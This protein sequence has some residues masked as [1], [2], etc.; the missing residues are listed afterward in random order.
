[1]V[2]VQRLPT[3]FRTITPPRSCRLGCHH[4]SP[5]SGGKKPRK[6]H[7]CRQ[8]GWTPGTGPIRQDH[9]KGQKTLLRAPPKSR[10]CLGRHARHRRGY[11]GVTTSE[12]DNLAAEVAA[13]NAVNHPDYAQ[14]A[15]RIAVSN[16]HK[17]TT[18]VVRRGDARAAHLHRP[19]DGSA[20]A[21]SRDDVMEI[22]EA[23]AEAS[24][25]C[26]HL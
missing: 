3:S 25:L 24:G 8:T 21:L 4:H 18:E 11:D 2:S 6:Q 15:S 17:T 12:L 14:L 5:R 1:M 7:V 23:N 20:A 9:G 26:H 10:P 13:T 19:S 22:I 16:L